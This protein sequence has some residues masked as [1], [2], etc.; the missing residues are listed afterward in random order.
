MVVLGVGDDQVRVVAQWVAWVYDVFAAE[1]RAGRDDKVLAFEVGEEIQLVAV[2]V[3]EQRG[4]EQQ[5]G[6]GGGVAAGVFEDER[7][8]RGFL[9]QCRVPRHCAGLA[10]FL[11]LG[12]VLLQ[13]GVSL[14]GER[15]LDQGR[16]VVTD[17]FADAGGAQR[18]RDGRALGDI[19]S[20][21]PVRDDPQHLFAQKSQRY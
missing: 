5:G 10:V 7:V 18:Q 12:E 19:E 8:V 13:L 11:G 9:E 21:V 6:G 17:L 15:T 20:A 4:C 14:Q 16:I 3:A 1:P 2:L